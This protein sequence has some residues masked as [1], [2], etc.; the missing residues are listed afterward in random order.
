MYEKPDYY[1]KLAKKE[2]YPARSVY[3]LQEIDE[4]NGLV[5]PGM[6]ILDIGAAPGSWSA[7]CLRK[8]KNRGRVVAV[9]LAPVE[10]K[11]D[12][13]SGFVSIEGDILKEE[14]RNKVF[15]CAPFD[16]VVSDAAPPTTGN[17]TVDCGRSY[18]LAEHVFFLGKQVLSPGGSILIKIFQGGDEREIVEFMKPLFS[19]V[20]MMKPKA[21]R[22]ESFEVF[23]LGTGKKE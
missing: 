4:K 21:S 16:L 15:A 5:K 11:K 3:K 22:K 14:T 8:Q 6:N 10:V 2:G 20:K 18:T 12:E 9:D 7:Y 17:R 23:I 13:G 19:K 1:A